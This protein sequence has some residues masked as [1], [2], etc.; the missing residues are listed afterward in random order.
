GAGGL[1]DGLGG[2]ESAHGLVPHLL[3]SLSFWPGVMTSAS[4]SRFRLAISRHRVPSPNL[5]AAMD[6]RVS[7]APTVYVPPSPPPRQDGGGGC[8]AWTRRAGRLSRAAIR[9]GR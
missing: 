1:H 3:G 8:P 2:G 4:A 6:Q 5:L 7:P 9:R